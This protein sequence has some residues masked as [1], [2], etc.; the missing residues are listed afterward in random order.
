MDELKEAL[1]IINIEG[2]IPD[3]FPEGVYIRNGIYQTF[4]YIIYCPTFPDI[5]IFFLHLQE[6]SLTSIDG[7]ICPCCLFQWQIIH[8]KT[9]LRINIYW[10]SFKYFVWMCSVGDFEV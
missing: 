2:K 9:T 4:T 7:L 10:K 5:V 6:M 8:K 1:Q 3:N